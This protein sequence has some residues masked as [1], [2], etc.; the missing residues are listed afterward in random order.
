MIGSEIWF[1]CLFLAMPLSSAFA[2]I[3][4]KTMISDDTPII[5]KATGRRVSFQKYRRLTEPD[6]HAYHLDP[7]YDEYGQASSFKL[8]STTAKEHETHGFDYRDSTLQLRV[9][10]EIPLFIMTGPDGKTYRSTD[11]KGQVVVLSFW[12]SLNNPYWDVKRGEPYAKAVQPYQVVSLGI[13][14][15][16]RR[17]VVE[18]LEKEW[19]PFIPIPDS[20]GFSRKFQMLG[21]PAYIIIDKAGRVAGV[22]ETDFNRTLKSVL[23][24]ITQ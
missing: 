10:Q 14:N 13:V 2:Q 9:G 7:V 8:R 4:V 3:S 6:P 5:D 23:D 12:I 18:H 16:S 19:L 11:L 21:S 24:K 17:E 1:S 20:Y 22:I 15:N